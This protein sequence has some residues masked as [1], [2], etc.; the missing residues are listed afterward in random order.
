MTGTATTA[1]L[2]GLPIDGGLLRYED[3]DN[4][5]E[6]VLLLHAGVFSSWFV[7]LAACRSLDDFRVIRVVLEFRS[8]GSSRC[9]QR[10]RPGPA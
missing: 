8:S 4:D 9:C 2:H 3:R 7:P 5:G 10:W 6:A 1:R